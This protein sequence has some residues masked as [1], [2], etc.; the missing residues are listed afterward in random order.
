MIT[1]EGGA[2]L[3]PGNA[4]PR[5]PEGMFPK[6]HSVMTHSETTRHPADATAPF[7]LQAKRLRAAMAAQGNPISH[8]AALELVASQHGARDWNTL[9]ASVSARKTGGEGHAPGTGTPLV[10][11]APGLAVGTAVTGRYLGQPFAGRLLAVSEMPADGLFRVTIH[12]DEP[13]DV[14]TFESF[15]AF[16]RRVTGLV[17]KDGISPRRT[18]NGLPHLVIDG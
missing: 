8:S 13:V 12:F 6:D 3:F 2:C 7:K 1:P 18:S 16:R 17:G 10:T 4:D 5:L 14:V 11:A 9:S 15:S